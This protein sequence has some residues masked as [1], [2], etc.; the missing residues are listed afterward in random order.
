MK[1]QASPARKT[2]NRLGN[3]L[4]NFLL[5]LAFFTRI[6]LPNA[7]G[8]K[9][10][11]DASLT[12]AIAFFPVIGLLIGII[13]AGVWLGVSAFVPPLV[14]AGLTIGIG[15]L[16]TGALHEDGFADCADGLGAT[17]DRDKA[18]EIMRDS[19][20]GAYGALALVW[21]IGIRWVALASLAPIAGAFALVIAHA[22]SR[23]AIIIAMRW[24]DYARPEGLGKLASGE[25]SNSNLIIAFVTAITIALVLG[26]ISG[27]IALA[28]GLLLAWAFLVYLTRRLGGYT[29]DGL[30]A[31]QQIS[32]ISILIVLA[33]FWT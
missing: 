4:S 13:L 26:Q 32:E 1:A 20:V 27:I 6:P 12:E 16:I 2:A 7:F 14:A 28:A 9:I 18:L 23:S 19:R 17:P 5:T 21:T 31:M 30:G 10:D 29:G 15:L 22:G 25:A 3:A 11:H 8:K 33:G 24:A